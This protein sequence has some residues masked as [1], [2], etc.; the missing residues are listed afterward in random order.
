LSRLAENISSEESN[1][2]VVI[3]AKNIQLNTIISLFPRSTARSV[4]PEASINNNVIDGYF[5]RS[6][7]QQ[8]TNRKIYAETNIR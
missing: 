2:D 5:L 3:D 4:D 1:T 6:T 8:I 7:K